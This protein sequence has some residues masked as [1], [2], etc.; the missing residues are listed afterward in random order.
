MARWGFGSVRTR[1]I[2]IQVAII[3]G[4]ILWLTLGWP[5]I[6]QERAAAQ[7]ARREQKIE[8][9]LQSTVVERAGEEI[10]VPTVDGLRRVHPQR[11][12][13]TPA[14]GDVQQELG[15]PDQSM[16][17]SQG[18]QHLI[19]I[20]TRHKLDASFDKGRLYAVTL[21]NLQTGHGMTVYE[22]SAQYH[23]F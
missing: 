17:D 20:G 19:W 11:L 13:I 2:V 18:G 8:S 22:S 6:Q 12:R 1:T 16:T 7:L 5:R 23:P 3:A 4:V 10:E 14:V 15:A 21:T 9:F